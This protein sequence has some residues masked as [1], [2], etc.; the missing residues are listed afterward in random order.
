MSK[1]RGINKFYN[2]EFY[3][4]LIVDAIISKFIGFF[5]LYRQIEKVGGIGS[6][7]TKNEIINEIVQISDFLRPIYDD[8]LKE[9][10]FS[11][12]VFGGC[13]PV[14]NIS[15]KSCSNKKYRFKVFVNDQRNIG[16][17]SPVCIWLSSPEECHPKKKPTK[18]AGLNGVLQISYDNLQSFLFDREQINLAMPIGELLKN[19]KFRSIEHSVL[20]G[21]KIRE[22]IKDIYVIENKIKSTY[23]PEKLNIR[24]KYS[25]PIVSSIYEHLEQ[26]VDRLDELMGKRL[27]KKLLKYRDAF[28]AF[29]YDGFI[30]VDNAIY[31]ETIKKALPN[32]IN[33][34]YLFFSD[35]KLGDAASIFFSLLGTCILNGIDP[36]KWLTHVILQ[37]PHTNGKSILLLSPLHFKAF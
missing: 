14:K 23:P 9:I 29:C 12:R 18:L 32:Y 6:Y 13:L 10:K 21:L 1:N 33:G 3:S 2:V 36:K 4:N 11:K 15:I 28:S 17:P 24:M 5:P 34:K 27:Y 35:K 31:D 16:L 7:F 26:N 8:I 37:I 22:L 25:L 20:S 30:D 19:S